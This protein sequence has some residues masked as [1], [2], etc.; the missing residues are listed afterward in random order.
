MVT[1]EDLREQYKLDGATPV[2]I[3][4]KSI[5]SVLEQSP[6]GA[7]TVNELL[8][9]LLTGGEISRGEHRQ[10]LDYAVSK[11]RKANPEL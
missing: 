2:E 8:N 4:Q 5:D 3:V 1:I 10:L 9:R 7:V 6:E 11:Y